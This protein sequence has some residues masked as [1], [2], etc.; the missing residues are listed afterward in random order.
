Q[1]GPWLRQGCE[2]CAV[3]PLSIQPSRLASRCKSRYLDVCRQPR[4]G[5]EYVSAGIALNSM[6][7]PD[8]ATIPGA[9]SQSPVSIFMFVRNGAPTLRR[10]IDSVLAQTYPNIEFIVQDGASTDGTLDILRSYGER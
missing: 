4:L 3:I 9:N 10:A 2:I 7:S 6:T 8:A 5:E 1:T